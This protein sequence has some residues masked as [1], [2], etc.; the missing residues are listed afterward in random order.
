MK[1]LFSFI[2]SVSIIAAQ[3]AEEETIFIKP[4]SS[5]GHI[6]VLN[7]QTLVPES[8]FA[9][10][11]DILREQRRYVFKFASDESVLAD[12]AIRLRIVDDP[13]D[14]APMT[15]SPEVGRGVLNVAALTNGLVSAESVRKILPHR[16]RLEFLRLVCYAFGVGGSQFG[17]NILSATSLEDLDKMQ[18]FL[19]VD[20]FDKIEKSG[21]K[22]GLKPEI[23]A[24][25]YGACEQG[26]APAPVTE[27]QKKIWTLIHTPP[28]E[29]IKIT[30]DPKTDT[31]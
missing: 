8:L 14:S 16:A 21:A 3:A 9:E 22:R 23:A 2:V 20:A 25:Y 12:A 31:K 27:A 13:D 28:S 11:A 6:G 19:P 1:A 5:R 15:V 30:F 7:Q 4:G 26:W 10:S 18:S 24:D 29:P 17:G